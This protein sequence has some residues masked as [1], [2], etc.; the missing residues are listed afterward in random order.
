MPLPTGRRPFPVNG[1]RGVAVAVMDSTAGTMPD[2]ITE[3]D[4]LVD[5]ATDM[6]QFGR[7]KKAGDV[8]DMRPHLLRRVV[9]D[10]HERRKAQVRH[11]AP[12]HGLH[13]AQV[14]I[15]QIDRLVPGTQIPCRV[16]VPR[17]PPI[18]NGAVDTGKRLPCLPSMARPF[19]LS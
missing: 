14:E 7:G 11:L 6:T 10:G 18:G 12:P 13:T 9:Q 16:P 2:T 15:L 19:L 5:G 3:G 8:V 17:C 1:E 4:V